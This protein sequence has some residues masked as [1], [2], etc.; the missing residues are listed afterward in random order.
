M[1]S[2]VCIESDFLVFCRGNGGG[3]SYL[4]GVGAIDFAGSGAVH[5]VGGLAALTGCAIIGPRIGR[6]LPDGTV[7]LPSD[8]RFDPT[9]MSSQICP[10]PVLQIAFRQ[11]YSCLGIA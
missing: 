6:F 4:A 2:L 5:M 11:I 8:F 3:R 7:R 9:K 1:L 10:T